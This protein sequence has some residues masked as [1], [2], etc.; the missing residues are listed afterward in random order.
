[1]VFTTKDIFIFVFFIKISKSL[2]RPLT[3]VMN[4][5]VT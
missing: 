5:A 2:P 1:M 4:S 3:F